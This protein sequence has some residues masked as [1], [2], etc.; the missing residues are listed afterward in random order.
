VRGITHELDRL[1]RSTWI[2][3]AVHAIVLAISVA[4]ALF[5]GG[6]VAW[7]VLGVVGALFLFA[8]F[9]VV[10]RRRLL[11][12]LRAEVVVPGAIRAL[13]VKDGDVWIWLRTGDRFGVRAPG[14]TDIDALRVTP[15]EHAVL[16]AWAQTARLAKDVE[17]ELAK[18]S[19]VGE[20]ARE[21]FERWRMAWDTRDPRELPNGLVDKL[22]NELL[23]KSIAARD[24]ERAVGQRG[25]LGG[26]DPSELG[27]IREI[28]FIGEVAFL[29]GRLAAAIMPDEPAASSM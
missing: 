13:G 5:F 25:M 21:P 9:A 27:D 22:L 14:P 4:L 6:W 3:H 18:P 1:I 17:V 24:Y 8:S 19:L 23:G 10:L 28:P 26:K 15:D 12:R 29:Q 7:T 20:L 16:D 2:N 11:R